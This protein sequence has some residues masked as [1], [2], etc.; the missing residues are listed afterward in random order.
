MGAFHSLSTG[1]FRPKRVFRVGVSSVM[2]MIVAMLMIMS[3]VVV[4][5]QIQAALTCTKIIATFAICHV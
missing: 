1:A 2:V 3:M 5:Y 4:V